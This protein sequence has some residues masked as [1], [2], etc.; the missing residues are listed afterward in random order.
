MQTLDTLPRSRAATTAAASYYQGVL[1]RHPANPIIPPGEMPVPCSSVFN[2]GAVWHEGRVLL[3]LRAED[4]AR[5]NTFYV[6][7]S[8]DGVRFEIE[9]EPIRYPLRETE[10]RWLHNRFDMR[11]TPMADEG[12]YYVSHASWLGGYGS[13]IGISRT[14]DFVDFEAVGELSV[15]SNRN[16]ALFPEKIGGRYARLERPQ[17]VDG[18]GRIWVSYSPDL[19]Y[20]GDSRPVVLPDVP[21]SRCKTGAGAVPIRTE[22]GW[23]C[24]YH[25]TAKNCATEN[26]YLGVMLLDL[27]RPDRVLAAPRQFILQPETVY[28]CIGQVPNVVFTNGAVVMPDGTLNIYYGGADTRVCLAQVPLDEL[29]EFCLTAK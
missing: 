19:I 7:T 22:A 21:W 8:E 6:A 3:L 9:R 1:H 20:W 12:V 2:C 24:V 28:E 13:C 27:E 5:G 10:A 29:V 15:P 26:Y 16:A 25:A 4:M 11:I 23:L 18:S 17:D 14:R